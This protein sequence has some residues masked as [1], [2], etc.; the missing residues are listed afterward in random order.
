MWLVWVVWLPSK[1]NCSDLPSR[2]DDLALLDALD[3]GGVGAEYDEVDFDLPA[4][5]TWGAPLAAYLRRSD[6]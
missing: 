2:D 1:A 3:A 6:L 5:E 4:S